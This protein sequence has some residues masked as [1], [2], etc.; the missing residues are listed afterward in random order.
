MLT[1]ILTMLIPALFILF[2]VLLYIRI[3]E[4]QLDKEIMKLE[5]EQERIKQA[6]KLCEE[7]KDHLKKLR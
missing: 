6:K 4:K 1:T 3:K 7:I 5:R 2:G